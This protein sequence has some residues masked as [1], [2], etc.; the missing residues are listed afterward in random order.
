[1]LPVAGT[2]DAVR[3]LLNEL[4]DLP[5]FL[6]VDGISLRSFADSTATAAS[7]NGA[8]VRVDLAISVFLEDPEL[9]AA[10]AST[11]QLGNRGPVGARG[12]DLLRATASGDDADEI[13]DALAHEQPNPRTEPG[14]SVAVTPGTLLHRIT[15]TDEMQVNSAHHQAARDIGSGVVINAVAPDGV[16]E[17]IE[18]PAKRFCLG[19]QWHPEYAIDPGDTRI[20]D[21][22][23]Q[24]AG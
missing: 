5:V 24:A 4:V 17:G 20:F 2:Y 12:A 6:V 23:V 21:A 14:H 10:T 9:V 22:F 3:R 7:R 19:V 18:L 8:P 1:M 13:A 16:I 11:T 15:G